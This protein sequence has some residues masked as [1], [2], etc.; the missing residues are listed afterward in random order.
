MTIDA[1]FWVAISFVLFFALLVYFKIP[2]KI[3]EILSQ[4]ISNI[5]NEIDES[6]KLR[7]EAKT[8]LDNSQTKLDNAS[9][10]TN[11]IIDQA[12]KDSERLVIELNE[13]F[14]K[15]AE[16]KKKLAEAK[17]NQMKEAAIKEIKDTSIKIAVDSVKKIISTSIDKNKLD[18]I[19]EKDLEEAK[20]ELKK[21]NS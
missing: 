5:K 20:A 13:K 8:L 18:K 19:F 1:T 21:I 2:Q 3:N 11:K 17:I 12:K 16:M 7:N 15:S 9:N 10:E 4:L 6:E 14:H